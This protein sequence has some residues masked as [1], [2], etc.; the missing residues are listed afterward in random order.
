MGEH[1]GVFKPLMCGR[2]QTTEDEPAKKKEFTNSVT[3]YR[4][5]IYFI[6]FKNLFGK[7]T[8]I[9]SHLAYIKTYMELLSDVSISH[10]SA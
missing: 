6:I 2:C 10:L 7:F 3:F 1:C 9:Y 5:N 4:D 8:N